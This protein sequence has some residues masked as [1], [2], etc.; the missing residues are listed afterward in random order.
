MTWSKTMIKLSS[1]RNKDSARV[2][3][4]GYKRRETKLI[5]CLINDGHEVWHT[6]KTSTIQKILT[7]Q[8]VLVIHTF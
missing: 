7:L 6:D 3:F 2:L 1:K 5:D 8:L 4:L